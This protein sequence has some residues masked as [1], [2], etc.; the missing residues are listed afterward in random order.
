MRNMLKNFAGALVVFFLA[1]VGSPRQAQAVSILGGQIFSTGGNVEVE[2]LPASAGFTS[3]LHLFS[4]GPD[5]FIARNTDVG[6]IVNLGSFPSG[7]EL[8]FG[9]FVE[10]TGNT[11][12]MGPGPRNPD[13][14]EHA[15]VEFLSPGV[16]NV[17]FEDLLGGGDRDY[18]DNIFQFRGG[19][20]PE[21]SEPVIPEPGTL[22][23]M[24]LGAA[25]G[26]KSRGRRN[27]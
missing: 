10:N 5:I 13:G 21:P 4:P 19:V 1:L 22:L 3:Q 18:N 24:S 6:T 26:L 7:V 16:A 14:I 12:F 25:A 11:F 8:I 17:G 20:A 23:L 9:I 15:T 27:D 2:V